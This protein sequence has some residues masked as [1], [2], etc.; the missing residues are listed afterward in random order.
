MNVTLE[1]S[2]EEHV[3]VAQLLL[4]LRRDAKVLATKPELTAEEKQLAASSPIVAIQAV[5]ER[6][7]CSLMVARDIVE[8]HRRHP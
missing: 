7:G 6:I 1:L 8:A 4:R 5:R 3:E 2:D